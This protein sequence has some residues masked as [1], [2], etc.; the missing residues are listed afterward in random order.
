M[1]HVL[2]HA[3]SVVALFL[4]GL[5]A[6]CAADG[7]TPKSQASPRRLT[8]ESPA[9]R[10]SMAPDS[11]AYELT[12]LR[13]GVAWSSNP[14]QPR[15]GTA[16]LQEDKAERVVSLDHFQAIA[17]GR[18]LELT[19]ALPGG[20]DAALILRLQILPD[21][22]TLSV[23]ATSV[24]PRLR[25]VRLLD[26][27]LWVTDSDRGSVLVPVRLGLLVAANSGKAFQHSFR[28]S[29]Y[30]GCH[31]EMVGLFKSG[32]AALLTWHDCDG[33]FQLQSMTEK[34]PVRSARQVLLPSLELAAKSA[35]LQIRL[36]GKASFGDVG[37]V[38]RAVAK[39]KGYLVTWQE[40]LRELPRREL[41]FGA[42]NVKL[43]TCL[44]RRM[45]EASTAEES[46]RVEWT[47]D[48][49]AQIAEHLK[50]DLQIDRVLFTLG[51]WTNGGYDCRHPDIM[52]AAPECG[53]NQALAEC[54]RR[55]AD[56]GYTLCLHDNYQ[57]MYHDARSFG[58]QWLMKDRQGKPRMGGRWLGG[59]AWLTCSP[60]A[61][62]LAQR[63]QN[64]PEVARVIAPGAYFID[65]TYA[66]DLQECFD[67]KHPLTRADDLHWKQELS[68][69]ARGHFGIF[70]SE[71][72]REWAIPCSDFFEGLSGVSG[73]HYHNPDLL[74]RLGATPLPIFEMV[75][76]DCIQIYGKYGYRAGKATQYVLHHLLVGRPLNYHQVPPG[77][78]W[79][80]TAREEPL[81][82]R[83][84]VA[85]FEP[86]GPRRFRIAYRW[87]VEKPVAG[88]WNTFV[89]FTNAN[90]R[91][92][93][94]GDYTPRPAV[95]QWR[96][97]EV[98]VGP[99]EVAVPQLKPGPV[100][101]RVGLFRPKE[102]LRATLDGP[103]DGERRYVIG[104]LQVRAD[105][106]AFEELPAAK[107]ETSEGLFVRADNGW[108]EGLHP[109]DRFLKNTHEI[110][111]PVNRLSAQ[112]R[113]TEYDLL[114]PDGQVR[115]SLFGDRRIEV[116]VNLGDRDYTYRS[117]RWGDVLLP[118]NGF[119]AH[120]PEFL[121]FSAKQFG[122]VRYE[123]VPLFALESQD[124]KPLEQSARVRVYHGFGDSRLAFGGREVE[125]QRQTV[126]ENP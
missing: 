98:T 73:A 113:M 118:R 119:L 125:V 24:D 57:D 12:D 60:K 14:R 105:G 96:P 87:K 85:R 61:L 39:Q 1:R 65:T 100:D 62:Q 51:G 79:R 29:G 126:L 41:L 123:R 54:A 122:G 23:V 117:K 101:I 91:I 69:Y 109:L 42:S 124:Q 21:E 20:S 46:V 5:L 78:Y 120:S 112:L 86:L 50:K 84:S 95:G 71:C 13:T 76:H 94:Q 11:G 38:Y 103:D 47:F 83:P 7:E 15:L 55:V 25:R 22:E 107:E 26:D 56:L 40:K 19:H 88:E 45:N 37:R 102:D 114:T 121:A 90:G 2:P 4:A 48:Q 111:S 110:L 70:G 36:L 80:N 116:V 9:I 74:D 35:R 64:L 97:G 66:V 27:A 89:H 28:T 33:V 82:L 34:C 106:I 18:I 44:N 3:R 104:R 77:L 16:V 68:H 8:I 53:G 43:W 58:E 81:H 108:A 67:P 17:R 6:T 59:R 10:L 30:E 52:P 92:L 75:Y 99:F 115:R 31:A 72:G 93:F 32:S 49:A 63:Q